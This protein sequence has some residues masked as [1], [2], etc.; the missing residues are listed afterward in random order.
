MTD[1]T[2]LAALK[3]AFFFHLDLEEPKPFV[4]NSRGTETVVLVKGGYA[5]SLA[6]EYPFDV[7]FELGW[8]ILRTFT[9]KPGV[10]HLDC[11]LFGHSNATGAGIHI[12]YDGVVIANDKVGAVLAGQSNG[13]DVTDAY[14][15]NHPTFQIGA[16]GD[17]ES[18]ANGK[19][20]LGRGKFVRDDEGRLGIEYYVYALE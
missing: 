15:T 20:F 12:W 7:K 3:P 17:V 5:E 6:P 8:D 18:W 10:T 19:N 9:D 14:V 1:P 11:D 13:H 2:T 16:S 4:E